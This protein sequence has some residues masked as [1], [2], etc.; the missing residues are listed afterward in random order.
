M[1]FVAG[2]FGWLEATHLWLFSR[3]NDV[4]VAVFIVHRLQYM[5]YS[6][7]AAMVSQAQINDFNVYSRCEAQQIPTTVALSENKSTYIDVGNM[8]HNN[9]NDAMRFVSFFEFTWWW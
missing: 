7:E 1:Y 5:V 2:Q 4:I 8:E 6:S 9:F 3:D